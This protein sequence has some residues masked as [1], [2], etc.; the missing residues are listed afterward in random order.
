[1]S[2]DYEIRT[3]R[4]AIVPEGEPIFHAR[5]WSIEIDDEGAGEYLRVRSTDDESKEIRIDPSEWPHLREAVDSM[6]ARCR[7]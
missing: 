1:M 7:G 6:A 3:T 5:A 2:I 4:I